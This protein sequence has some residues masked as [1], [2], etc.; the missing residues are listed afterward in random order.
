MKINYTQGTMTAEEV[1]AYLV[2]SGQ[3]RAVFT[4]I[5]ANRE[6]VKKAK[7]MGLVVSDQELQQFSDRFR[8]LRGLS[9]TEKTVSFLKGIGMTD[10]DF[11]AFCETAILTEAVKDRLASDTAQEEF[12]FANRSSF[13]TARVS[14]LVVKELNLANEIIIMIQEDGEDFHALARKYSLDPLTRN[15]GGYMGDISRTTLPQDLTVKIFA[16]APGT[17]LGPYPQMDHFQLFLVEEVVRP[18]FDNTVKAVIR[19]M[20]FNQWLA[21]LIRDGFHIEA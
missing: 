12:F 3:D 9:T 1:V 14:T 21:P 19:E 13:E 11:E 7:D 5:M 18:I 17:V 2:L 16:A 8:A 10:D 20:L 15:S 6:I 4:A